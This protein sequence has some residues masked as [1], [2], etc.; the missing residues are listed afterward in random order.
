MPARQRITVAP[1]KAGEGWMVSVGGGNAETYRTKEQ[2]VRVG[3]S[4]GRQHGH[5]QLIIKG[6]NGKIQS[7]RTYGADPSRANG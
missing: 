6:R 1:V 4:Q 3:A 5:A 7:E 2:A